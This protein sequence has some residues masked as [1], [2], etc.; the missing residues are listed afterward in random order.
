M[1][2]YKAPT[3]KIISIAVRAAILATSNTGN[4]SIGKGTY[5]YTDDDFEEE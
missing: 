5:I 4:E 2:A 3:A 1:K